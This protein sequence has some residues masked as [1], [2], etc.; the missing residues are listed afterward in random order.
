MATF[1]SN[2]FKNRHDSLTSAKAEE[3]DAIFPVSMVQFRESWPAG[4]P[5]HLL[6]AS[7]ILGS[8]KKIPLM[9]S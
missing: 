2:F 9:N 5:W 3:D 7:A 6:P 1:F 4:I 8:Q